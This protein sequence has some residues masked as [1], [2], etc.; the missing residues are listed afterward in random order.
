M[1]K[2]HYSAKFMKSG[3]GNF[4]VILWKNINDKHCSYRHYIFGQ[5]LTKIGQESKTL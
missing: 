1:Y 5:A 3:K 4:L 2:R